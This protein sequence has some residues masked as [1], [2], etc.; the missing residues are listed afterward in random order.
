MSTAA[1]A[2]SQTDGSGA[3]SVATWNIRSGRNGG[4]ESACRALK[5]A[6]VD[7][8]VLQETKLTGGVHTRNTSGYGIV[9]SKIISISHGRVA[10]VWR[11]HGESKVEE[12]QI[13]HANGLTF[14][15]VVGAVRLFVVGYHIPPFNLTTL[16]HVRNALSQRPKGN[17]VTP[18]NS[19]A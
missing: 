4:I 3:F 13:M 17:S 18:M 8:A 2:P 1:G 6:D 16:E 9:A 5:S 12:T 14:Q 10:L 19:L 15:L 7:I 11:K